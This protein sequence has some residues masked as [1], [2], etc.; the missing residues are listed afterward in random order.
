MCV[1]RARKHRFLRARQRAQ[2]PA[3][4]VFFPQYVASLGIEC[5]DEAAVAA[6]VDDAVLRVDGR[7]RHV[8]VAG[9]EPP[10]PA[11]V[12]EVDTVQVVVPRADVAFAVVGGN[13]A[14][15]LCAEIERAAGFFLSGR[16][17]L[18]TGL[19]LP[20]ELAVGE[21][22]A[23]DDA[24]VRT[25]DDAPG[26]AVDGRR[27]VRLPPDAVVVPARLAVYGVDRPQRARRGTTVL[28]DE[29]QRPVVEGWT[30][31]N[32]ERP[33]KV[34]GRRLPEPLARPHVEGVECAVVAAE[35]HLSA[36][37]GRRAVKPQSRRLGLFVPD[38]CAVGLADLHLAGVA[39]KDDIALKSRNGRRFRGRV[40]DGVLFE[41]P[42]HLDRLRDRLLGVVGLSPEIFLKQGHILGITGTVAVA[43]DGRDTRRL[44]FGSVSETAGG[45]RERARPSGL[46]EAA[47]RRVGNSA[48]R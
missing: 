1:I 13:C 17:A 26:V 39:R 44:G 38:L 18:G 3:A 40:A 4:N 42:R 22:P 10:D 31:A 45:T 2:H 21:R 25:S 35:I 36:H 30:G 29:V 48:H 19:V 32:G 14:F 23:V 34:C 28:D 8:H 46:E 41:R 5:P 11:A 12:G 20:L 16:A 24:V 37:D 7:I 6:G 43:L 9:V 47:A 27:G 33:A 15:H